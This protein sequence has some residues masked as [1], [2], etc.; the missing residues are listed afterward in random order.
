MQSTL[1]GEGKEQ[2]TR[3]Q[4]FHI[5]DHRSGKRDQHSL[6]QVDG[7]LRDSEPHESVERL[8]ADAGIGLVL[9]NAGPGAHDDE[10]EAEIRL[11]HERD[12]R[13]AIASSLI[14][15]GLVVC[16]RMPLTSTLGSRTSPRALS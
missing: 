16:G 11:L 6:G 10:D 7:A 9:V 15:F 4:C 13:V 1:P 2:R 3:L 5:V 14:V 8:D 12:G